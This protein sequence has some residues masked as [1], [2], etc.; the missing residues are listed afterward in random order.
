MAARRKV[1]KKKGR[2]RPPLHI[3]S[4]F[5]SQQNTPLARKL[6]TDKKL[7]SKGNYGAK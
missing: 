7:K 5:G 2:R 6:G 3:V 4:D 1:G